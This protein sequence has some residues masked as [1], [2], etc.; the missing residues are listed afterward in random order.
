MSI[1]RRDFLK[2]A[3]LSAAMTL[4]GKSAFELFAPGEAEASMDG[5]P[6]TGGNK[7]GMVIDTRKTTDDMMDACQKACHTIHN[8]P[9]WNDNKAEVKWIWTDTFTHTFP[10]QEHD[11][12]S[13]EFEHK[14]FLRMLAPLLQFVAH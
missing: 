4:G 5:L 11:Y 8:V 2:I 9:D 3:G 10:T 6:L 12:F 13:E 7:Y 14:N 1:K